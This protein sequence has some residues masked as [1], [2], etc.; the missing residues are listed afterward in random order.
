VKRHARLLAELEHTPLL[1]AEIAE[2]CDCSAK[3]AQ[4]RVTRA[5][6]SGWIVGTAAGRG[7]Q[8]RYSLTRDGRK[9]LTALRGGERRA[10]LRANAALQ[11]QRVAPTVAKRAA[12]SLSAETRKRYAEASAA[13]VALQR[14]LGLS[15]EL[16]FGA[17]PGVLPTKRGMA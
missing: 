8:L 17:L 7:S 6:R 2:R 1:T 9:Y 4:Q 15:D 14:R 11:R 16:I 10:A 5:R 12:K 13:H 3:A